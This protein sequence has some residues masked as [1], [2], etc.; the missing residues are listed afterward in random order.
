MIN[1]KKR[2]VI[3]LIAIS[4][5]LIVFIAGAVNNSISL[6]NQNKDLKKKMAL[7]NLSDNEIEELTKEYVSL[8]NQLNLLNSNSDEFQE[9][10]LLEI[11]KITTPKRVRISNYSSPFQYEVQGKKAELYTFSMYGGYKDLLTSLYEIE[12]NDSIQQ[13]VSVKFHLYKDRKEKTEHLFSDLK[14]QRVF[15]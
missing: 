7:S 1:Y 11:N 9:L 4:L 3:F 6:Y 12:H 14:L 10:L 15:L 13:L 8:R 2:N 5:A